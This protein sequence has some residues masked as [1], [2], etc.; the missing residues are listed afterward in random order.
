MTRSSIEARFASRDAWSGG[1]AHGLALRYA[2][3]SLARLT[4]AR[5][6]LWTFPGLEGCW[7]RND[8]AP[9]AASRIRSTYGL[10]IHRTLYGLAL[11][12]GTGGV[13]CAAHA[14]PPLPPDDDCPLCK[15]FGHEEEPTGWVMFGIPFGALGMAYP[16]GAYPENDG[17]SLEWR[18]AVDGWLRRLAD[19]VHQA[20][21]FD[22]ALVGWPDGSPGWAPRRVEEVERDRT[23]GYLFPG[24]DGLVWYPPTLGAPID[25]WDSPTPYLSR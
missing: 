14:L 1:G 13:P 21:P 4:A 8:R 15:V 22:A 10:P 9:S 3:P 7:R 11:L 19:H 5:D 20:A 25:L 24:P 17:S 23:A 2:R 6:A 16:I 18:D 12:P